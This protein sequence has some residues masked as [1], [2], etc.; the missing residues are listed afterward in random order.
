[1][2]LCDLDRIRLF[3]NIIPTS[4]CNVLGFRPCVDLE[5]LSGL[6]PELSVSRDEDT[7]REGH[8][9][10]KRRETPVWEVTRLLH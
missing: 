8:K 2:S 7:R 3:L 6:G 10:T 1:M 4:L 5:S 9:R